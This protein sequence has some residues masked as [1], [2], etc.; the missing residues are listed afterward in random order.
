MSVA[1][2]FTAW[3]QFQK[4]FRPVRV[5]YDRGSTFCSLPQDDERLSNQITPSLRDGLF[6]G[7]IPG[8]KLP[9]YPHKVPP[10]QKCL[11][12]K[13]SAGSSAERTVEG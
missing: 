1:W 5:P 8:S 3:K 4:V 6:F 12:K 11:A 7:A 10:G 2:Q 9:G 13:I